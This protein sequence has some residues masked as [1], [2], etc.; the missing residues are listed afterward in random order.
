MSVKNMQKQ[1][2]R[3]YDIR[4]KIGIDI[5]VEDFYLIAHAII[6]YFRE[7]GCSAI[8]VGMDGRVHGPAIFET[9]ARACAQAGVDIYDLGLCSTP[10]VQF[11]Q[12]HLPVQGALM[13]TASH[14]PGHD[15]G[16]KIYYNKVSVQ[17]EQLQYVYQLFARATMHMSAVPGRVIDAGYIIDEYIATLVQE[18]AHLRGNALPVYIDCGNGCAGPIMSRLIEKMG[19]TNKHLLFAQVDGTYPNHCA[20]PTDPD[21]VQDLLACVQAHQGSFGIGFDGDCDRCAII[22]GAKGLIP[23]DQTLA[24]LVQSMHADVVVADIKSSSVLEWTQAQVVRTKTGCSSIKQMMQT[25][26]AMIGGELSGHFFFKDRHQGYDDGIYAMLR[27]FEL[28]YNSTM[29]FDQLVA[30]LPQVCASKDMR[31][32]CPDHLK[33]DLVEKITNYLRT[34]YTYDISTIDGVRWQMMEGWALIR[35]SNT[36]PALSICCQASDSAALHTIKKIIITLLKNDIDPVVLD[37][38][39]L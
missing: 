30:T 33:F 23:A 14:N 31:V 10:I 3:H 8:V 13:I 2:F 38:Y 39:L 29:T 4:G 6:A 26:G 37:Q 36:Q 25:A 1:L 32:P 5:A 27:F 11:A 22:S 24:L 35:A 34:E 21:N 19:W 20:D 28:V 9:I 7:Q 18:F 16:L 12:Y 15:N 17:G